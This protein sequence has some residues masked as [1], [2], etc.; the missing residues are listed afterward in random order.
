MTAP[1]PERT[2][3]RCG[4]TTTC[5]QFYSADGK[6]VECN[7]RCL[8]ERKI[9]DVRLVAQMMLDRPSGLSHAPRKLP[10]CTEATLYD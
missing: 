9:Q 7:E 1:M 3:C 10:T 2:C 8:R 6:N 4:Q 5:Y